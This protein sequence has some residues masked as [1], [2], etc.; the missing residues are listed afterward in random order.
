MEGSGVLCFAPPNFAM[1]VLAAAAFA[2][3]PASNA[4]ALAVDKMQFPVL[5]DVRPAKYSKHSLSNGLTVYLL[6]DHEVPL[7]GGTITF[8]GGVRAEPVGKHGLAAISA[9]V[10]RSGGSET[11]PGT[12][13]DELL[14]SKAAFIGASAEGSSFSIAFSCLK[15]DVGDIFPQFVDLTRKPIFPE[16]K[17]ALAKRQVSGA[18]SRR[19]D[20]PNDIAQREVLKLVYGKSSPYAQVT[21]YATIAPIT[22]MDLQEFYQQQ[23]QPNNGTLAVVGDFESSKML[24]EIKK[25]LEKD[26][27]RSNSLSPTLGMPPPIDPQVTAMN[28]G[29][30]FLVDKPE[31]SQSYVRIAELGGMLKDP[32]YC[33]LDVINQILN[34]L[35]GRLFNEIRSKDGLAYSVFGQWYATFDHPGVFLAGGETSSRD[36]KQLVAFMQKLL[37]TLHQLDE[38][39]VTQEEVDYA[40]SSTLNS[41]VFNYTSVDAVLARAMKYAFYG[42][43]EDFAERYRRGV[44]QVTP[45]DIL[46]A[47]RNRIREDDLVYLVVGNARSVESE[48]KKSGYTVRHLDITI[49]PPVALQ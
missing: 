28:R 6:E 30:V 38:E 49:P 25:L 29:L 19:N 45:K 16:D 18:I 27:P 37:S 7:V 31:L 44:S 33:T 21:E 24:K 48:L 9:S 40:T 5:K 22:R 11:T 43:P 1:S 39:E 35:G 2:V 42:Y 8:R 12:E 34:G 46:E 41:F 10:L 17:I 23:A 32:D 36:G 4:L 26:W 14:A 13:M 15:E 47:S 20:D 3:L